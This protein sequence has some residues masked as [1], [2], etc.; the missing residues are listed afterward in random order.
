MEDD[1]SLK[2]LLHA[3]LVSGTLPNLSLAGSK[4][5]RS[6]GWR[7][8][9]VFLR[10]VSYSDDTSNKAELTY[11]ARSLRYIDLSDTNWDKRA[12]D[13][14]GQALTAAAVTATTDKDA[15]GVEEKEDGDVNGDE[16]DGEANGHRLA[17]AYGSFIPPAPLLRE[18]EEAEAGK[19]SAVQTLRMD[20]CGLRANVL[21]SLGTSGYLIS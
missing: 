14:L 18:G 16:E 5:I 9:A 13:Y 4:K 7:L 11:Q 21:E 3:L 19:P 2:T 20:G 8:L 1:A 10:K 17:N 6:S 15:G 12:I